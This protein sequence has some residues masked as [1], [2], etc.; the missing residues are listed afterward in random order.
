VGLK[1]KIIVL[2]SYWIMFSPVDLRLTGWASSASSISPLDALEQRSV[3]TE[4]ALLVDH[5]PTIKSERAYKISN[6]FQS[7]VL[8]NSIPLPGVSSAFYSYP[9]INFYPR[10]YNLN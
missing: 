6:Q 9:F 10:E 4:G 5:T 2:F 8:R 3:K 7:K 1:N